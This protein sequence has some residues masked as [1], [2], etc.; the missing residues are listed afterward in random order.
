MIRPRASIRLSTVV[1]FCGRLAKMVPP[2]YRNDPAHE[3]TGNFMSDR[4]RRTTTVNGGEILNSLRYGPL[5]SLV[6][7]VGVPWGKVGSNELRYY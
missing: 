4:V 7:L 2:P 1:C 6:T 5:G 3:P